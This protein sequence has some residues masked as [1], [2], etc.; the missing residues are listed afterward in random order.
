ML[1][2][3]VLMSRPKPVTKSTGLLE[4]TN[5]GY[6][7]VPIGSGKRTQQFSMESTHVFRS[8]D[9]STVTQSGL[10]NSGLSMPMHSTVP[11]SVT[12]LGLTRCRP[13]MPVHPTVQPIRERSRSRHYDLLCD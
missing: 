8:N 12:R 7:S 1:Q 3:P 10:M 5:A 9:S 4:S 2:E 13:R 6:K 11:P